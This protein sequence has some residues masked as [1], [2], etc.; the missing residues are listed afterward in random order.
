[1]EMMHVQQVC[2]S[3]GPA[4]LLC[5]PACRAPRRPALIPAATHLSRADV[6]TA[7]AVVVEAEEGVG[8][9]CRPLARGVA[10]AGRAGAHPAHGCALGAGAAAGQ[11]RN[12]VLG[13]QACAVGGRGLAELKQF[14]TLRLR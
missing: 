1:M 6:V 11:R 3:P 9:H 8:A 7:A 2:R 12:H 4:T 10:G 14:L 5:P 13:L